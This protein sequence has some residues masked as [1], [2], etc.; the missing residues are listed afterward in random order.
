MA[1]LLP[2]LLK[3]SLWKVS[4]NVVFGRR[5]VIPHEML[6][7]M[8]L[9]DRK[10]SWF[11]RVRLMPSQEAAAEKLHDRSGGLYH[12]RTFSTAFACVLGS[13]AATAL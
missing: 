9:V 2:K 8:T 11:L 12:G 4:D 7:H 13:Q 5:G 1:L 3:Q 6:V 10:N